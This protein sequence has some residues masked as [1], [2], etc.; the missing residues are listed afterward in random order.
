MQHRKSNPNASITHPNYTF[1]Q[2]D[3]QGSEQ[4]GGSEPAWKL[5]EQAKGAYRHQ[6]E[7]YARKAHEFLLKNALAHRIVYQEVTSLLA[8]HAAWF[9]AVLDP[10]S[11]DMDTKYAYTVTGVK[12]AKGHLHSRIGIG[13][14][15]QALSRL[16]QGVF[17]Q[18]NQR[19]AEEFFVI[20]AGKL[21]SR[22][23]M[24]QAK[25]STFT[26]AV[27]GTDC[28]LIGD[29]KRNRV[30]ITDIVPA[31]L[32]T[33]AQKEFLAEHTDTKDTFF[34][35]Q[36]AAPGTVVDFDLGLFDSK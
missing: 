29:S 14:T 9:L 20:V 27:A 31:A 21:M 4:L 13:F 22:W 35:Q 32:Y 16:Y 2:A 23:A 36:G 28:L 34:I 15:K 10:V 18:E 26:M 12:F 3:A 24:L 1:S 6:E 8:P 7:K 25:P 17:G 30:A 11:S 33:P 19:C 5:G